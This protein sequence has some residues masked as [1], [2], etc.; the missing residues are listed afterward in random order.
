MKQG[1]KRKREVKN[2]KN[3]QQHI[4]YWQYHN[5]ILRNNNNLQHDEKQE[6]VCSGR[7]DD[8]TVVTQSRA[9]LRRTLL[10]PL[11]GC[12]VPTVAV[13]QQVAEVV[14]PVSLYPVRPLPPWDV[15]KPGGR[16]HLILESSSPAHWIG[17]S[18]RESV[19]TPVCLHTWNQKPSWGKKKE[20]IFL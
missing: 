10:T 2:K 11:I 12:S 4:I 17:L 13:H 18:S 14:P 7:T 15:L 8:I 20:K 16:H 9:D 6:K 3:L 19:L 5:I 1:R